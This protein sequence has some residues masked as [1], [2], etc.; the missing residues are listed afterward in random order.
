MMM[1]TCG[2]KMFKLIKPCPFNKGKKM[3]K[4]TKLVG[5]LRIEKIKCLKMFMLHLGNR[6][7]LFMLQPYELCL[8]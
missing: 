3:F 6:K 1:M 5:L 2:F 4:Q 8:E 7:K